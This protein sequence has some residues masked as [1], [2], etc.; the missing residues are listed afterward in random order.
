MSYAMER[1]ALG[2]TDWSEGKPRRTS[3]IRAT[4]SRTVV[5]L[6]NRSFENHRPSTGFM[7]DRKRWKHG[8]RTGWH[9]DATSSMSSRRDRRSAE[10][11]Y[12]RSPAVS[13]SQARRN[14]QTLDELDRRFS[15]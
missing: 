14:R 1:T 9:S 7:A 6:D 11:N 10:D 5:K 8:A 4:A 12:L 15:R 13:P 3:A 2:G